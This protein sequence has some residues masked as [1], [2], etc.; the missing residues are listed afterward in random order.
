VRPLALGPDRAARLE[1]R[2]RTLA[3]LAELCP[4]L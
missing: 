1:S 3:F 2:Q 4:E